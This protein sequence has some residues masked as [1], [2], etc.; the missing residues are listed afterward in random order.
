MLG[1]MGRPRKG[2]RV[3]IAAKPERPL[4]EVIQRNA[5]LLGMSYGDYLVAIAAYAHNMPEL[6]PKPQHT[7]ETLDGLAP[8]ESPIEILRTAA[9]VALHD[10]IYPKELEQKMAS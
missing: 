9:P 2:D 10:L 3:P 5:T 7:L 6:A 1:A 4:A 8:D